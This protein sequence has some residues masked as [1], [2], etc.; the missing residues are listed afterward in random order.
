[1]R[2]CLQSVTQGKA[3]KVGL[4][5]EEEV[6][7]VEQKE[8]QANI[9]ACVARQHELQEQQ[10][11]LLICEQVVRKRTLDELEKRE[12]KLK[13]LKRQAEKH[14]IAR[15]VRLK[16]SCYAHRRKIWLPSAAYCTIVALVL[17]HA[18]VC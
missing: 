16:P 11:R 1:M 18:S 10:Q 14:D 3:L 6:I 17:C 13:V 8:A 5:D 4:A 7:A 15:Q 12:A 2:Y 9:A